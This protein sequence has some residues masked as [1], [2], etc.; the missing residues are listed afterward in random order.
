MSYKPGTRFGVYG[1]DSTGEVIEST[2]ASVTYRYD[3]APD[4]VWG[5]GIKDFSKITFAL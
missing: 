3:H 1:A 2:Q 4:Q 5:M